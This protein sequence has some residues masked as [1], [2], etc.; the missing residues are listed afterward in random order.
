MAVWSFLIWT[1]SHLSHHRHPEMSREVVERKSTWLSPRIG[2]SRIKVDVLSSWSPPGSLI[3]PSAI[4]KMFSF[5]FGK[6]H[7]FRTESFWVDFR[8][9]HR[10]QLLKVCN[11]HVTLPNSPSP[12]NAYPRNNPGKTFF[13][14]WWILD[15]SFAVIGKCSTSEPNGI[16]GPL[17]GCPKRL[18]YWLFLPSDKRSCNVSQI[19]F[20]FHR[21][22]PPIFIQTWLQQYSRGAFLYSAHGSFSNPI[23]F[24]SVWCWRTMISGKIFTG[25]AKF[26]GIVSVHDFRLSIG[27]QELLQASLSFLW[28]FCFARICLDPLSG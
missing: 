14:N 6:Y 3:R 11:Q 28:S 5:F 21:I 7:L 16:I 1:K 17:N 19:G 24:W 22:C 8:C 20:T 2:R 23:C 25:F 10:F 26:Q 9:V 27:L 12:H 4:G 18:S 15:W 13:P